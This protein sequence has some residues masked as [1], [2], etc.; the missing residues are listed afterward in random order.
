MISLA[1]LDQHVRVPVG[2]DCTEAEA[3]LALGT[4]PQ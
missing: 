2:V 1:L 4:C 3:R